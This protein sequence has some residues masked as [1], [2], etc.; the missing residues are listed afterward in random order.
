MLTKPKFIFPD[1][2]LSSRLILGISSVSQ[3]DLKFVTESKVILLTTGQVSKLGDEVLGQGVETLFRKPGDQEDGGLVSQR[4]ILP[5]SGLLLIL[6]GEGGVVSCCKL[7][8]AGI[9]CSCSCPCGS[10]HNVPINLQQDKCSL[11]CNF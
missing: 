2:F 4:T 7:L 11:F 5:E 8:G 1:F 3:E 10:S 6:K 9:L